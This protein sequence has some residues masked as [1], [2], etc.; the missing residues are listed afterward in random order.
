MKTTLTSV[1]A[2]AAV[3]S[4]GGE[5]ESSSTC[6]AKNILDACI[7]NT[8]VYIALCGSQDWECLCDKYTAQM[9]MNATAYGS[10]TTSNVKSTGLVSG[11]TTGTAKPTGPKATSESANGTGGGGGATTA[12]TAIGPKA[13]ET[14]KP[15]V[16]VA[17]AAALGP[18]A[19]AMVAGIAAVVAAVL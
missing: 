19:G 1:V 3:I 14:A 17:G 9:T 7:S 13:T 4:S 2:F 8:Q 10:K 6:A 16:Q 18:G 12:E 11:Q 15:S 5:G